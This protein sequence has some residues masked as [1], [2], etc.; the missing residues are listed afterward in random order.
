[1]KWFHHV[2]ASQVKEDVPR[3]YQSHVFVMRVTGVWP[4]T[5]DSRWYRWLTIAL[6]MFCGFLFPLSLSV[7][8]LFSN[9]MDEAME[10]LFLSLTIWA[11]TFKTVVIYWYRDDIRKLFR[12]HE[13]LLS[14]CGRNA[15]E[16]NRIAWMNTFAH[17]FFTLMYMM[18]WTAFV[19]MSITKPEDAIYQSTSRLPYDF[20]RNR[21][22][23]LTVLLFQ[24]LSNTV[25]VL[26]GSM[27]DSFYIALMN[28]NCGHVTELK[29][30]LKCL[31]TELTSEQDGD[32][33]F[34]K[35]LVECCKRYEDCLK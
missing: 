10:H 12:I 30:R 26:W 14:G 24:A 25:V 9:S 33:V 35:G 23:Y 21:A 20:A 18:G 16:N 28:S 34:Y 8:I 2:Y 6:F 29:K 19:T 17:A 4:T 27:G 7:N 3:G 31:G 5:E 15:I 22:V 11:A 13:A 32:R 1:M